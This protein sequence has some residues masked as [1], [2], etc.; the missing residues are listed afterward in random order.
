M[1]KINYL[2]SILFIFVHLAFFS[3]K[4][5]GPPTIITGTVTN[6][7]TGEPVEGAYL[8][9]SYTLDN[10]R[11]RDNSTF[12]DYEGKYQ[13]EIP[14][15]H[16]F[17][18]S[19]VYYVGKFLTFVGPT[20][21]IEIKT[22]ERNVVDIALIP[23]DGFLRVNL[24]NDLPSNDSLYL[25]FFNPINAAQFAIGAWVTPKGLPF[26]LPAG[27]TH[28]AVF[29]FPSEVLTT[30]YW[31]TQKFSPGLDVSLRDSVF[32]SRNDTVDFTIHF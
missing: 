13:L 1:N 7:T 28:Q 15:E 14:Q 3:C 23:N 9:C 29:G 31:G 12:S 22:G 25:Y 27:G 4:K 32:L 16:S 17:S 30:F 2:G 6:K 10:G 18:F 11:P 5:E 19:A 26:V 24:Q 8:D 21:S 20:R